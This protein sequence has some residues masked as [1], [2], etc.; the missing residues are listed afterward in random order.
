[1]AVPGDNINMALFCDFENVALGVR[2]ANYA[3]FDIGQVLERL[4]LKGS[5]VVKVSVTHRDALQSNLLFEIID[6]GIGMTPEQVNKLFQPFSQADAST[7]R[8]YGGT[9]LGLSIA[10]WIAQAH[11]GR[12][13]LESE[14]DRGSTFRMVLPAIG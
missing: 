10:Y 9:G 1:M 4:L 6:T 2:E 8:K 7:T 12:I 14:Q 5:I 13:E 11:G 3:Q